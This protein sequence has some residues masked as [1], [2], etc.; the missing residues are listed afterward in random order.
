MIKSCDSAL[1]PAEVDGPGSEVAAEDGVAEGREGSTCAVGMETAGCEGWGSA[2][3]GGVVA[4]QS[5][6]DAMVPARVPEGP[7][8][9]CIG[10]MVSR[11]LSQRGA[12]PQS[13]MTV[14]GT[15]IAR[16][17]QGATECI[18]LHER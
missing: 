2:V 1:E 5:G 15:G 12:A 17:F 11:A 8:R 6:T 3:G 14:I 9:R 18:M 13:M 16:E 10:N 4:N 7:E